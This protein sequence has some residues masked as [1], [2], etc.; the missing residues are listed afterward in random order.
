MYVHV[1]MITVCLCC[2]CVESFYSTCI[3]SLMLT[4]NFYTHTHR[5]SIT[6]SDTHTYTTACTY[7][8]S[9]N[10]NKNENIRFQRHLFLLLNSSLKQHAAMTIEHNIKM[11]SHIVS[12]RHDIDEFQNSIQLLHDL[13]KIVTTI[14]PRANLQR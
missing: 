5:N 8:E 7:V 12:Q 9:N 3:P 4:V 2:M 10:D 13:A 14:S 6:L 11:L 1:S